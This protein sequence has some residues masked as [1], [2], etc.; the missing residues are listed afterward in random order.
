MTMDPTSCC[1]PGL[2][3]VLVKISIMLSLSAKVAPK[4]RLKMIQVFILDEKTHI[5]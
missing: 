4:I 5:K 3:E 2:K 1:A